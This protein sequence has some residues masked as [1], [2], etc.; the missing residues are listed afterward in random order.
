MHPILADRRRLQVYLV[1]WALVGALLSLLVRA[2]IGAGWKEAMAFG[3]PLGVVA[4]PMSL[5]SWYVCRAMPLSRSSVF[6]VAA[7]AMGAAIVTALVWAV[8]GQ[9]WW[10]GLAGLGFEVHASMPALITLVMSVGAL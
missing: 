1:A 4:A 6:R 3:L 9:A 2:V 7:T 10:V 8:I 5:S